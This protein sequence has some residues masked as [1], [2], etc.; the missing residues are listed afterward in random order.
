MRRL[1]LLS[2][3]CILVGVTLVILSIQR[4]ENFSMLFYALGNA[5][6]IAPNFIWIMASNKFASAALNKKPSLIV[7]VLSIIAPIAAFVSFGLIS[8]IM[9]LPDGTSTGL[10][11]SPVLEGL[12]TV[13]F[14]TIFVALITSSILVSRR[15]IDTQDSPKAGRGSRIFVLCICFFYIVIGMFFIAP[16][17]KKLKSRAL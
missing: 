5:L 8:S 1:I 3:G 12:M 6:L 2:W 7:T 10:F 17:L 14:L 13:S 15:V 4:Q 16:K 9:F 11:S